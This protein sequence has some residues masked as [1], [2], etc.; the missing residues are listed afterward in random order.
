MLVFVFLRLNF[1]LH[2]LGL[3]FFS[4][5]FIISYIR[6]Y[7][8]TYDRLL[9]SSCRPSYVRPSVCLSVPACSW[10]ACSYI[11]PFYFYGLDTFAVGCIV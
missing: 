10:Q 7:C 4:V 6:S 1:D 2:L 9:A 3:C 5:R 11:C 8:Y